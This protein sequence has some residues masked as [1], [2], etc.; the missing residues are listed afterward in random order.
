MQIESWPIDWLT[1]Y[2]HNPR[3]NDDAVD[4]VACSIEE[5]GFRQPIVVDE[6][7]VI[8][9]GHTRLKAAK[10]LGLTEIP[11]HVARELSPEKIKA[12]RI[13][14]NKT[15]E[16]AEWDYDLL[17]IELAELQEMDFDIDLLGFSQ[18]DLANLLDPGVQEGLTDPDDV[19]EPPDEAITQAGDLWIL[20]NHRL[21]CGDS[22]QRED[23]DLLLDGQ[24]VHLVNM[25]PP[26]NVKVEPRSNGAPH[27]ETGRTG[28]AR[29][30]VF[31]PDRRERARPVRRQRV[32]ADGLRTDG[33]AR[34][35]DGTRSTILRCDRPPVGAI[36]RQEGEPSTV[37]GADRI[38]FLT[39]RFIKTVACE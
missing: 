29:H 1:P 12:L 4:S 2:E 14:D 10:K 11:V 9:I 13:A 34:V 19:P 28:G 36:Q 16:L 33:T 32:D 39:N 27:R 21:L 17:P 31:L 20:G 7:G 15:A 26:Y 22:S 18:D 5:F 25:D 23:L 35:P 37:Q 3:L 38:I 8:I 30:P 24:P 6:D